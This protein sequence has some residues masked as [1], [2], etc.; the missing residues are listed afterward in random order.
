MTQD[1]QITVGDELRATYTADFAQASSPIL[2]DGVGTPFQTSHA[3]HY[4][5]LGAALLV[6]YSRA[7]G[8]PIVDDGE[9]WEWSPIAAD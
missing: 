6:N 3:R 8:A 2:L 7:Q 4:P 5:G 9:D 1:Y